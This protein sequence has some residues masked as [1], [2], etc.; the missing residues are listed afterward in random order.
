MSERTELLE[1]QRNALAS[2]VTRQR[3]EIDTLKDDVFVEHGMVIVGRLLCKDEVH[4]LTVQLQAA[5]AALADVLAD[6]TATVAELAAAREL[7]E[8]LFTETGYKKSYTA[9]DGGLHPGATSTV[10]AVW[11]FLWPEGKKP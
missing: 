6:H 8:E 5:Q 1:A 11:R 4:A 2:V 9:K 10:A 7:L 3:S